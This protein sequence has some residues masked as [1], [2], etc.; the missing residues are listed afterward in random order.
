MCVRNAVG[1]ERMTAPVGG[2]KRLRFYSRYS[3]SS[4]KVRKKGILR[5]K[6]ERDTNWLQFSKDLVIG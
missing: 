4:K 1:E 6:K 5:I 3:R 2:G